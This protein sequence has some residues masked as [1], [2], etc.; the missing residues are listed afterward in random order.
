MHLFALSTRT[1]SLS[2]TSTLSLY[3]PL[4][5]SAPEARLRRTRGYLWPTAPV[6]IKNFSTA[7]EGPCVAGHLWTLRSRGAFT[8]R[9]R[10]SILFTRFSAT[11]SPAIS[12]GPWV[13]IVRRRQIAR[14]ALPAITRVLTLRGEAARFGAKGFSQKKDRV[15]RGCI[16][17]GEESSSAAEKDTS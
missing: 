2:S 17:L 10:R 13:T 11:C 14:F 1:S 7:S 15:L 6:E 16:Y 3:A 5:I 12:S 9:F 4:R 8:R